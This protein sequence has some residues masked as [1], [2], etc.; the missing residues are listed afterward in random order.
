MGSRSARCRV[1]ALLRDEASAFLLVASPA[2]AVL[3]EALYFH[4]RLEEKGMP[5]VGVIVNRMHP[6][7]AAHPRATPAKPVR[8]DSD[9]ARHL[10]RIVRDQQAVARA[11]ARS[12]GRLE[13]DT[14]A[15]PLLVPEFEADIHDLRDLRAVGDAVFGALP[16]SGR[17]RRVSS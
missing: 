4:R 11:E 6:D 14:G 8:V 15:R 9:L 16:A 7:P 17:S 5:L 13:V 12:V 2:P 3:G 10:M 1:H